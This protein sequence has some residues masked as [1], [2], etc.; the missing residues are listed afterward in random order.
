MFQEIPKE[1]PETP[2][3][4][5][6]NSPRDVKTLSPSELETLADEI[7][8]FLLY[9]IGKTGGH[10]GAG[11]DATLAPV[12]SGWEACGARMQV[13]CVRGRTRLL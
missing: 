8:G 6:I 12:S 3:L 7:R 4:D 10:L 13:R 9:T 5:L 2:V 1:K 11:L